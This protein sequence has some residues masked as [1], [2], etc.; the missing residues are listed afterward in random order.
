MQIE[1]FEKDIIS[2]NINENQTAPILSNAE[3]TQTYTKLEDFGEYIPGARKEIYQNKEAQ[4]LE[5]KQEQQEQNSEIK[6]NQNQ[7]N[8]WYYAYQRAILRTK[9]YAEQIAELK[10]S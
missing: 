6:L 4:E 1:L 9:D 7:Q 10:R 2:A 5:L 3:Q 8:T